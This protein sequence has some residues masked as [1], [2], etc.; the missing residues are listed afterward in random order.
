[1]RS[2]YDNYREVSETLDAVASRG[3]IAISCRDRIRGIE[4]LA[5][6]QR[7]EFE[8]YIEKR[9]EYSEFVRDRSNLGAMHFIFQRTADDSTAS[10]Q[11]QT[12]A[13]CGSEAWLPEL[14]WVP[15]CFA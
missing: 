12:G 14:Q 8:K 13:D 1:M 11:R 2:A 10:N 6:K 9:M 5:A 7:I 3:P 4:S 15:R